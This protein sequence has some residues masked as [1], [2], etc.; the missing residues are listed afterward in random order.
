MTKIIK[1]NIENVFCKMPHV[2]EYVYNFFGEGDVVAYIVLDNYN[3]LNFVF[4]QGD[5]CIYLKETKEKNMVSYQFILDDN[6]N[7]MTLGYPNFDISYV[8]NNLVFWEENGN[9]QLSV[10]FMKISEDGQ[11]LV[12]FKQYDRKSDIHLEIQCEQGYRVYNGRKRIYRYNLDKI[13][14]LFVDK[15]CSKKDPLESG[16]TINKDYYTRY[17]FDFDMEGYQEQKNKDLLLG[18]EFNDKRKVVRYYKVKYIK[19][20]GELVTLFPIGKDFL[21]SEIIDKIKSLGFR[22]YI[23]DEILDTFNGDNEIFND[24]LEISRQMKD[25]ELKNNNDLKLVLQFVKDNKD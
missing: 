7:F 23:P 17:E 16:L 20:D 13:M 5:K 3:R 18:K 15:N 4:R 12:S 25:I 21:E 10:D 2:I 6:N 22:D 24:V 1:E 11:G 19:K 9:K 14:N 8:D